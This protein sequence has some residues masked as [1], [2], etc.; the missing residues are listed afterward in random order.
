MSEK[1]AGRLRHYEKLVRVSSNK[2]AAADP[3]G[4]KPVSCPKCMYYQPE[5][6]YRKCLYARC[7]FGKE[8]EIFRRKPLKGGRFPKKDPAGMNA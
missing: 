4:K 8:A 1:E 3:A 7:P 2:D 6:E 5:F